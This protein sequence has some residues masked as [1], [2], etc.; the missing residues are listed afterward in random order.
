MPFLLLLSNLSGED[1]KQSLRTP[2]VRDC[3]RERAVVSP[4][5]LIYFEYSHSD[6][7]LGVSAG[8][9]RGSD[10]EETYEKR[11]SRFEGQRWRLSQMR[12]DVGLRRAEIALHPSYTTTIIRT[13]TV[14]TPLLILSHQ[15]KWRSC[16]IT[17]KMMLMMMMIVVI[18]AAIILMLVISLSSFP[19]DA[20]FQIFMM[21]I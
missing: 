5:W 15:K 21:S 6:N 13:I 10:E 17:M 2:D 4:L 16:I 19:P 7:I 11:R 1:E 12:K 14:R 8:G 20:P 3:S 9:T 18:T